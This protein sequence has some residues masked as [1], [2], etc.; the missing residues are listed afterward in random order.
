MRIALLSLIL[1]LC[2]FAQW[3]YVGPDGSLVYGLIGVAPSDENIMYVTDGGVPA[4]IFRTDDGGDSWIA[5]GEIGIPVWGIAVDPAD[6]DIVYAANDGWYVST[7]TVY[8]SL[9]GGATWAGYSVGAPGGWIYDVK[10]HPESSSVVYAAGA[11][12]DSTNYAKMFVFRSEDGG[13]TW[14]GTQI[15][16]D[17][18][19]DAYCMCVDPLQPA[20]IYIGGYS[21]DSHALYKS[22]DG[23]QTYSCIS[24]SS[25]VGTW[26][27]A[28]AVHPMN[29]AI[30]YAVGGSGIYRSADGGDSWETVFSSGEDMQAIAVTAADPAV[31]YAASD[32][33]VYVSTDTGYTWSPTAGLHRGYWTYALYV[34]KSV[35]D[36]VY[37]GNYAGFYKTVNSGDDWYH[38]MDG[39][40][41]LWAMGVG[42][43]QHSPNAVYA[44]TYYC[45]D[46][47]SQNFGNDWT[48]CGWIPGRKGGPFRSFAFHNTDPDIVFGLTGFG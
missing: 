29:S 21:P 22:T 2:A 44:S 13:M 46:A 7:D 45:Y 14:T 26:I 20:T 18:Y 24:D 6:P 48:W 1:V 43:P 28:V 17:A 47:R 11:G 8:K 40:E 30:V 16:S 34:K 3:E 23:G 12:R 36:I 27:N 9:D 38:V 10:V 4:A 15:A 33:L 31:V 35:P 41:G 37:A 5:V 42:I 19:S 32:T 39:M 25:S